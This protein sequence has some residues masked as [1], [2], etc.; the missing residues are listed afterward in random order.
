M[1]PSDSPNA[2][3]VSD[4]RTV[5]TLS[6]AIHKEPKLDDQE[7]GGM[8]VSKESAPERSPGGSMIWDIEK[9]FLP[10]QSQKSDAGCAPKSIIMDTKTYDWSPVPITP[11]RTAPDHRESLNFDKAST[12]APSQSASQI[13]AR[14]GRY[15]SHDLQTSKY[16]TV[17][18]RNF[19]EEI[20]DS[21][22]VPPAS[23]ASA[24]AACK[25]TLEKSGPEKG[26]KDIEFLES[27]SDSAVSDV[28]SLGSADCRAS[29]AENTPGRDLSDGITA[30]YNGCT[31]EDPRTY[32]DGTIAHPTS[33]LGTAVVTA[34]S[35]AASED[36]VFH[37][38]GTTDQLFRDDC[39]YAN[40]V[41]DRF[42][43]DESEALCLEDVS[44][45]DAIRMQS[46]LCDQDVSLLQDP[47]ACPFWQHG[48]DADSSQ[49]GDIEQQNMQ[50]F[51]TI[52]AG[53]ENLVPEGTDPRTSSDQNYRF[54]CD[55]YHTDDVAS[56]VGSSTSL[57]DYSESRYSTE[58]EEPRQPFTEGRVLLRS[59]ISPISHQVGSLKSRENNLSSVELQVA[60]EIQGHWHPVKL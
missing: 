51:D 52:R 3:T 49:I 4:T 60:N 12:L 29:L 57:S 8:H 43:C 21:L 30:L 37:T 59:N 54:Y 53:C 33:L 23:G 9:E 18:D 50:E 58:V 17:L 38:S 42:A 16:F 56:G 46:Q 31:T 7:Q 14:N 11:A 15:H 26:G 13:N 36:D 20:P 1:I 34:L 45:S 32:A 10:E 6:S 39:I 44:I 25:S 47:G 27:T 5:Q 28:I 19:G 22:I 2:D 55:F 41:L 35:N 24:P 48:Y 40:I